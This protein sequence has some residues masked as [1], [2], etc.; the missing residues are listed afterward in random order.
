MIVS[1]AIAATSDQPWSCEKLK[2][3]AAQVNF[4]KYELPAKRQEDHKVDSNDIDV[5]LH[6]FNVRG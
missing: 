5:F 1:V 4:M 2:E 6:V 3:F